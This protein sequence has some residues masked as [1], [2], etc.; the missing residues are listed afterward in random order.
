MTLPRQREHR[1][2][3]QG[4]ER[5]HASPRPVLGVRQSARE[6]LP[7]MKV[8]AA[9]A[10]M[11]Y[12]QSRSPFRHALTQGEASVE[13]RAGAF[14]RRSGPFSCARVSQIRRGV[15][16][17]RSNEIIERRQDEMPLRLDNT[18]HQRFGAMLL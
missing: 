4:P 18:L 2:P 7:G 11:C 14:T 9:R 6:I 8:R 10:P 12:A 17:M 1:S 13:L 16:K 3:L 5:E 15:L